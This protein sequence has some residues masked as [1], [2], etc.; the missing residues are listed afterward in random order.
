MLRIFILG[1]VM[2]FGHIASASEGVTVLGSV[3]CSQWLQARADKKSQFQEQYLVGLVDGMTLGRAINIWSAKGYSLE[4]NQFFY[5]MDNYCKNNPLGQTI[6]GAF[7]F[8]DE[9][10]EGR[11]TKKAD[12]L[13]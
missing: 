5:W 8:A 1:M 11:F 9:V 6:T 4:R 12:L 2:T 13:R 10:T 3:K 7:A